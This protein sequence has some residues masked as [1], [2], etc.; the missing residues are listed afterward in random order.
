MLNK[1]SLFL[2]SIDKEMLEDAHH[3]SYGYWRR[4]LRAKALWNGELV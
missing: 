3:F 2:K 1:E 4:D